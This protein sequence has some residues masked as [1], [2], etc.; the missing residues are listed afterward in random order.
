MGGNNKTID[1]IE[2]EKTGQSNRVAALI[3]KPAGVSVRRGGTE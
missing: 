3:L 1:Q 2:T